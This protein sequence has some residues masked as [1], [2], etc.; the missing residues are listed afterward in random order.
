MKNNKTDADYW[1]C[2]CGSDGRNC[3]CGAFWKDVKEA[4]REYRDKIGAIVDNKIEDLKTQGFTVRQLTSWQY[5]I[6]NR[7]DIFWQ[8][9]RYHDI[10]ENKRGSYSDILT[11][12]NRF[13]RA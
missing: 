12:V 8:S 6:N 4:D 3:G 2:E 10:K 1:K 11:F 5:R 13:F 7:L 9:R